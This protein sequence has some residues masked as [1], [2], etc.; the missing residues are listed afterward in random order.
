MK[1]FKLILSAVLVFGG[2]LGAIGGAIAF[3]ICRWQ[4]PDMTEIRAMMEFPTP[5]IIAVISAAVV[6]LGTRL[7]DTIKE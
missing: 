5:I 3:G 4:N 7:V 6:W 2:I 1:N